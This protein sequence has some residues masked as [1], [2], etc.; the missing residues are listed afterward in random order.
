M[1]HG[2]TFLVRFAEGV[3]LDLRGLGQTG[4]DLFLAGH[5][6]VLRLGLGQSDNTCTL[7]GHDLAVDDHGFS[8]GT[9]LLE[10]RQ[11][12][13][14]TVG[15]GGADEFPAGNLGVNTKFII[16]VKPSGGASLPIGR[17]TPAAYSGSKSYEVF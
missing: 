11:M 2:L 1:C 5:G 17:T 15:I 8:T 3:L 13:L 6:H 10:P 16:E 14:V 12:V 9:N 7:T 4:S